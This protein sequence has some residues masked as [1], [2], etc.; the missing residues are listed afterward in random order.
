MKNIRKTVGSLVACALLFGAVSIS[1]FAA[2]PEDGMF[3]EENNNI[4]GHTSSIGNGP[5]AY[6]IDGVL[7][8]SRSKTSV[9]DGYLVEHDSGKTFKEEKFQG[10]SW[11]DMTSTAPGPTKYPRHY[12]RVEVV[13]GRGG[14]K[15]DSG[16]RWTTGKRANAR[17][18]FVKYTITSTLDSWWGL[19]DK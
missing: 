6:Y 14:A 3:V 17:T 2:S 1:A 16:R 15:S 9:Y 11:T 8:R 7:Q 18:D 5:T 19:D 12:T 4:G 10:W 13:S